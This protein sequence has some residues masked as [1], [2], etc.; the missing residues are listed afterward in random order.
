M[1]RLTKIIKFSAVI[2]ISIIVISSLNLTINANTIKQ[3]QQNLQMN[4]TEANDY[5]YLIITDE[6]FVNPFELLIRHKERYISSTIVTKQSIEKDKRFWVNGTYG[7]ANCQSGGNKWIKDGEEVNKNYHLFNDSAAKIRN[8][9]RYAHE[10][11]QTKYVLIGGDVEIMPVRKFYINLSWYSGY[12]GEIP[13]NANIPADMYYGCLDGSWNADCDSKFG[14]CAEFSS[15]DEADFIAEVYIGRA[16]VDSIY[17]VNT[18]IKKV[19]SYE[20]AEKPKNILLH[21]SNLLPIPYPDTTVIPETCA[22]WIPDDFTIHRLY[23][24]NERIT[25]DKWINEFSHPDKL[26]VLQV[27]NG[28]YQGPTYSWYQL[29]WSI[30]GRVMFKN[31]DVCRLHNDFYPIHI[32][33]SCLQGNFSYSDCIAE[34]LLQW[35]QGGASACIFNSEVGNVQKG[36]TTKYSGEFIEMIFYEVFNN[37]TDGL[38]KINQYAKYHF[39]EKAKTIAPYRFC[40]YE[41]NLL[42]DPEMP[43]FEKREE[44]PIYR[45][46]VDEKYNESIHGWDEIYFNSIQKAIDAIPENGF[47]YV[48]NGVYN[49][50]IIINKTIQLIGENKN[51]TII[52]SNRDGAIVTL[53]TNSSH[54]KNFTITAKD[55]INPDAY[56]IGIFIP[57]KCWGNEIY[58]NKIINNTDCGVLISNSCRNYI[59]NNVIK[60]NGNGICLINRSENFFQPYIVIT[61][62]NIISHNEISYNNNYGL[63][64]EGTINNEI[65][66][67]TIMNNGKSEEHNAF[68][69][70]SRYNTWAGN[71]WGKQY[72]TKRIYGYI[73]P[74]F[75]WYPD[76]TYGFAFPFKHYLR[77]INLPIP[78]YE[79]D[80]SPSLFPYE[81]L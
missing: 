15:K 76:F 53:Q 18:F 72:D 13:I 26:L 28:Y 43:I 8:F 20:T 68:F 6:K 57:S 37:Q 50:N 64:L 65:L 12:V 30:F 40:Y 78:F 70:L 67:N 59:Y 4:E 44:L 31:Q 3:N 62:H 58:S 80:K 19:I 9:I 77:I 32:S 63:Y 41:I 39:S 75:I 60:K 48:A 81:I 38:G 17:D 51:K 11:W 14:E 71:Y 10:N 47:I 24:K 69:K 55:D 27:G 42:G 1:I 22:I 56:I 73:G 23:Q 2:A 5:K 21:Q 16:P 7:D 33:I 66:N 49:E 25:V 52:N 74:F 35:S 34:E 45:V 61:C 54:I 46:Y 29:Y 79:I 36:N